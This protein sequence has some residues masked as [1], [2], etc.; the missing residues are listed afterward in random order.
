VDMDNSLFQLYIESS[1]ALIRAMKQSIQLIK[2]DGDIRLISMDLQIPSNIGNTEYVSSVSKITVLTTQRIHIVETI[3]E[4]IIKS[5]E[6]IFSLMDRVLIDKTKTE[7][8]SLVQKQ[9]AAIVDFIS[10][11]YVNKDIDLSSLKLKIAVLNR[12][13]DSIDKDICIQYQYISDYLYRIS[14]F[15]NS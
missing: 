3:N 8:C 7:E 5:C 9:L 1:N 2:I 14:H 10:K 15:C 12:C 6:S 11:D 4:E 13:L